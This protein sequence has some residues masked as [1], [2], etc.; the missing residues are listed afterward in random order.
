MNIVKNTADNG[1]SKAKLRY[2]NEHIVAQMTDSQVFMYGQLGLWEELKG[3]LR[4]LQQ[5]PNAY[6]AGMKLIR[7]TNGDSLR[8]LSQLKN[9]NAGKDNKLRNMVS[10]AVRRIRNR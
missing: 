7:E 5:Y 1:F 9:R 8:I 3:F 10:S 4:E 2:I 6:R